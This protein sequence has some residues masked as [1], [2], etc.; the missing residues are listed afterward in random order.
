MFKEA[1]NHVRGIRPFKIENLLA[2]VFRPTLVLFVFAI[3]NTVCLVVKI[4]CVK[5]LVIG[6]F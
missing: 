3:M 6:P 4:L 1:F 5:L 2:R